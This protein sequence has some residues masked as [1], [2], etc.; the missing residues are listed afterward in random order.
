[1]S[2]K[3]EKCDE[4]SEALLKGTD[5]IYQDTSSNEIFYLI[6]LQNNNC[7]RSRIEDILNPIAFE[8]T[9]EQY[10]I[11]IYKPSENAMIDIM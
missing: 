8:L 6:N 2:D 11:I 4:G 10:I 5:D 1:M 7:R 9:D 3:S